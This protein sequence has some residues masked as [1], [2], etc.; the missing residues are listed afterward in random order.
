MEERLAVADLK[1][2]SAAIH[3]CGIDLRKIVVIEFLA[4]SSPAGFGA[5]SLRDLPLRS[6]PGKWR[7][8]DLRRLAG[9]SVD[10]SD[11]APV[12]RERGL[13]ALGVLDGLIAVRLIFTKYGKRPN[14]VRLVVQ[15][16]LAVMRPARYRA[17]SGIGGLRRNA[18][19]RGQRQ[20]YPL[21]SSAA[22]RHGR[23]T[24]LL[25]RGKCDFP[26]VRRPRGRAAYPAVVGE[27][28]AWLA[29]KIVEPDRSRRGIRIRDRHFL[30]IRRKLQLLKR[31][32]IA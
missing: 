29:A 30:P 32:R 11:P 24:R 7:H 10:V 23:D 9:L 14:H 12:R 15:Q 16:V 26:S 6:R 17:I 27:L 28:V 8:E 3:L 31:S 20:Q 25:V 4:V 5:Q 21:R 2:G 18:V 13:A 1:C 22:R 19:A